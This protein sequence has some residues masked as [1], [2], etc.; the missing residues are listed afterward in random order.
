MGYLHSQIIFKNQ[1][2]KKAIFETFSVN[3][4]PN[5]GFPTKVYNTVFVKT[6]PSFEKFQLQWDLSFGRPLFKEHLSG[7]HHNYF[8]LNICLEKHYCLEFSIT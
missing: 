6:D 2:I 5:N 3:A 8:M 7:A 4:G 1:S